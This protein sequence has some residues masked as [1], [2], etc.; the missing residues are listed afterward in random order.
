[1]KVDKS[2]RDFNLLFSRAKEVG[3]RIKDWAESEEIIILG[4]YD[5]DGIAATSIVA[6]LVTTFGGSFQAR[7]LEQLSIEEISNVE[8]AEKP[9]VMTDLGSG[10]ISMLH[11]RL[12]TG[13]VIIDHH[14][15]ER[16]TLGDIMQLNPHEFGYEGHWEISASGLAYFVAKASGANSKGMI[17]VAIIGALS[18]LQDKNRERKLQSLNSL[19]VNEGIELGLIEEKEDLLFFRRE[20]RPI[21]RAL[22]ESYMIPIPG[23]TGNEEAAYNFVNSLGIKVKEGERWRTIAE[24][25]EAEKNKMLVGLLTLLSSEFKTKVSD[26][27]FIGNV[28]TLLKEDRGSP[29]RDAREFGYLLNSL[30]RTGK[31]A[32]GVAICLGMRGSIL[33]VAEEAVREYSIKIRDSLN[34]VLSAP[35]AIEKQDGLVVIRG[36]GI[37]DPNTLSALTNML[38]NSFLVGDVLVILAFALKDEKTLK[39]SARA[40]GV[41]VESGKSLGDMMAAYATKLGGQGG[42]HSIA[43]GATIPR[44][45]IHKFIELVKGSLGTAASN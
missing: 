24:L 18:D 12:K 44:K 5:A 13:L 39:V 9:V 34:K 2:E 38:S 31:A 1:M 25:S 32:V 37:V 30:G 6:S 23:I 19:I 26:L 33:E 42:G 21:H 22:A 28:Y 15:P 10:Y 29:L 36:E 3:D 8:A 40:S 17:P 20:T 7:P 35:G 11:D 27:P 45:N 41:F 43:A 14:I 4:H 16:D